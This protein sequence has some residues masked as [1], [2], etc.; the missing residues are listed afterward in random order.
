MVEVGERAT[1]Q[2]TDPLYLHRK[3]IIFK[4]VYQKHVATLL[5][6]SLDP[7]VPPSV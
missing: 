6:R 2:I 1:Y 5:S 3:Q 4:L 7:S